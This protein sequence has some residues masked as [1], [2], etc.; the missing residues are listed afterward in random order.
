METTS[1]LERFWGFVW[2]K[3]QGLLLL[4]TGY[5]RSSSLAPLYYR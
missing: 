3:G 1:G 5:G 4:W 2:G